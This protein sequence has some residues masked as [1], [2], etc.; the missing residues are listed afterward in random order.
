MRSLS[1]V[2]R[3][4]L[5]VLVV[6]ALAVVPARGQVLQQVPADAM[7]VV[8]FTNL[9]QVSKKV[10]NFA[11]QLGVAQ[12]Q[13]E[14]ADPLGALEKHAG[15]SKGLDRAGDLVFAFLDPE[16][17]GGPDNSMVILFPVTNYQTFLSN[18]PDAKA[19]G[20]VTQATM[21]DDK[22]PAFFAEWGKYAAVS[23]NKDVVAQKP[24]GALSVQGLAAREM[25]GK[26]ATMYVN[27]AAVRA[28]ALPMIQGQRQGW[29]AQME[30]QFG[31]N[32]NAQKYLPLAKAAVN[33]GLNFAEQFLQETQSFTWGVNLTNDG[34]GSTMMVEFEP[35]SKLATQ[36]AR[37]KNTDNQ[38]MAGLPEGKYIFYGGFVCDP[39]VS[40]D[41][42]NDMVGPVMNDLNA[43]GEQAKPVNDWINATRAQLGTMT[44]T[45]FGM[46]VPTTPLGA[47]SVIQEVAITRGDA[48][49]LT[50]ATKENLQATN[51][52]TQSLQG[53]MGA[54]AQGVQMPTYTFNDNAKTVD[55]VQLDQFQMKLNENPQTPQEAQAT[56]MMKMMYGPQGLGGYI[57][58]VD[59]NKVIAAIGLDDATL[60]KA[61]A[62]AKG[63]QDPLAGQA[64]L[65]AVSSQLPQNRMGAAYL[66]LD[67]L[68]GTGV[69]YAK[70]MGMPVNL[71]LPPNLAP[72]G[73][74]LATEGSAIRSDV[75]I[76]A[77]L[78][79]SIVAASM[80]MMMQMQG[81][82]QP[83]GPGGL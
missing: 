41:I 43:V 50:K 2:R 53:M 51:A 35:A 71:Q 37:L 28:K 19:E 7:V 34:I 55:G 64:E 79:Q 4:A 21:G 9:E 29:V 3:G 59:P 1:C 32:P 72:I 77:Q 49:T 31:N 75:Y 52:L 39:K 69:N 80:Q 20:A 38:L 78:V 56:Q 45:S 14:F 13:P 15:V 58:A 81:G 47:G 42:F 36:V 60:A 18:F 48:A 65:K 33:A 66:A 68:I 76:P 5:W 22:K 6:A 73:M 67:Q 57:G 10:A 61:V 23:P 83:G 16:A 25:Q 54:A 30:Q 44:S 24:A 74:T 8:K 62:A 17:H 63:N 82:K 70:Q 11:Q 12:M 27:M 46:L 26:D 40:T